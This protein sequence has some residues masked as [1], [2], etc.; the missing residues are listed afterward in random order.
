MEQP[1]CHGTE[2]VDVQAEAFEMDEPEESRPA[3]PGLPH[4][5]PNAG[6]ELAPRMLSDIVRSERV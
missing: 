2:R 1:D 5:L 4:R 6:S 3:H